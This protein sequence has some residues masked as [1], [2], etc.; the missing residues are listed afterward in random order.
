MSSLLSPLGCFVKHT[1]T[2]FVVKKKTLLCQL[3]LVKTALIIAL[4]ADVADGP[5]S[6]VRAVSLRWHSN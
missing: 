5:N 2:H 1:Y 6:G 4:G 3:T